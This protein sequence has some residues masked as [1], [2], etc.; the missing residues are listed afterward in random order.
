MA[1]PDKAYLVNISGK[2][3]GIASNLFIAYKIMLSKLPPLCRINILGYHQTWRIFK[4]RHEIV[5]MLPDREP[6]M[7]KEFVF[8]HKWETY[9]QHNQDLHNHKIKAIE[10]DPLRDPVD[11]I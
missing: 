5:F 1:R 8:F 4:K 9:E 7:I 11:T 2:N 6:V 10:L 3:V